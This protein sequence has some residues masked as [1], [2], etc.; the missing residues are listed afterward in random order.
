MNNA[1]YSY[2]NFIGLLECNPG[3]INVELK[4]NVFKLL[5]R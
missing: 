1:H 4:K 3:K 5:L 2:F